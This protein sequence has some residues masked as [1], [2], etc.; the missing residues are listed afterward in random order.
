MTEITATPTSR[1]AFIGGALASGTLLLPGCQSFGGW[2]L[3]DAIRQLL[4]LS[5]ERAFARLTAPGGFWDEQV[6][7]L[8]LSNLIGS[9]GGVLSSILTSSLFKDR[10]EHAFADIAIEGAER[11]A[12]IVADAVR[13]IGFENALALVNGGPTAASQFL[14]GSMGTTLVEAM[15]PELG[16]AMRVANEPLVAELLA[17]LTGIDVGGV[18]RNLANTVDNAIWTEM[19]VEEAEIRRNPQATNDPLLIG[20]FGGA[21]AL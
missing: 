13:V 9:R 8:G 5:S 19:G 14:R 11:A 10:L 20:V 4:Y 15:V 16:D 7:A 2:S 12:P 17:G 6:A 18:A 3:T 21:G 1:R